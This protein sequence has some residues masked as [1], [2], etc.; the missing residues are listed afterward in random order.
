MRTHSLRESEA[1]ENPR[2]TRIGKFTRIGEFTRRNNRKYDVA[3]LAGVY[4]NPP[5]IGLRH[6]R[7]AYSRDDLSCYCCTG[8]RQE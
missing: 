7:I 6:R 4:K 5:L 1:Y 2:F 3:L 8:R